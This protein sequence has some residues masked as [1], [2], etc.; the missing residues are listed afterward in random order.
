VRT[1]FVNVDSEVP[2]PSS[3]LAD[4]ALNIEPRSIQDQAC[5]AT[6]WVKYEDSR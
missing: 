3:W 5:P 4:S 2:R 1:L 6:N